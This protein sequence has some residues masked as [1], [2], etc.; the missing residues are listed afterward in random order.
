[1]Y[2]VEELLELGAYFPGTD[3]SSHAVRT[4]IVSPGKYRLKTTDVYADG[5]G[6][7][8]AAVTERQYGL[9][10][11]SLDY[12]ISG[13]PITTNGE[14]EFECFTQATLVVQA[15]ASG[16][17]VSPNGMSCRIWLAHLSN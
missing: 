12:T 13:G 9:N 4:L 6:T 16:D 5:N 11:S 14:W 3:G 8:S 7:I 17:A 1:M 10:L 15:S 2:K